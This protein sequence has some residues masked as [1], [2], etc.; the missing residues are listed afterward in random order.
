MFQSEVIRAIDFLGEVILEWKV[1]LNFSN[2][3]L[4]DIISHLSSSENDFMV[5]QLFELVLKSKC[6]ILL[7][8]NSNL[9]EK[10]KTKNVKM[11]KKL[12]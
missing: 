6:E 3:L 11:C 1:L 10:L 7:T 4:I 12:F 8:N 9:L 5:Y 2:D